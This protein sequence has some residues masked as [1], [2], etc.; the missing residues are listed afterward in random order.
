MAGGPNWHTIIRSRGLCSQAGRQP[1]L[2]AQLISGL[3]SGPIL[4]KQLSWEQC[5]EISSGVGRSMKAYLCVQWAHLEASSCTK[6]SG[7]SKRR[8]MRFAAGCANHIRDS[9]QHPLMAAQLSTKL[10]AKSARGIAMNA[11]YKLSLKSTHIV[12]QVICPGLPYTL[13]YREHQRWT[14]TIDTTLYRLQETPEGSSRSKLDQNQ[15]RLSNWL[16]L[17]VLTNERHWPH[18]DLDQDAILL[19]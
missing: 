1:A 15:I 10:L 13:V 18:C 8:L 7:Q 4:W 6:P 17:T 16:N 12:C 11:W 2:L 14:M 9:C 19:M 3:F 5:L